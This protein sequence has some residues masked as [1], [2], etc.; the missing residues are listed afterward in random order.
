MYLIVKKRSRFYNQN[1]ILLLA[2]VKIVGLNN[3]TKLQSN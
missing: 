1:K 3:P 2:A